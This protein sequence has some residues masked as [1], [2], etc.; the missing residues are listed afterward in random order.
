MTFKELIEVTRRRMAALG[1]IVS[2]V[3][4]AKAHAFAT[5]REHGARKGWKT[6]A[7]ANAAG[8]LAGGVP[9]AEF[10]EFI[11]DL[12]SRFWEAEADAKLVASAARAAKAAE[13]KA[14][15]AAKAADEESLT[16]VADASGAAYR[17]EML[18]AARRLEAT[19]AEIRRLARRA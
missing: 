4:C 16:P 9:A 12:A 14:A 19:A 15:K 11:G 1:N 8:V 13:A 7:V 6:A 18:S 3:E 2:P 5:L 17:A 10:A